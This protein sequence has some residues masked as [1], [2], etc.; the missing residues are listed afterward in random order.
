MLEADG[1]ASPVQPTPEADGVASPIQPTPE[2]DG[3]GLDRQ[4]H[5]RG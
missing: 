2:A 1:V 3:G 4:V 5:V